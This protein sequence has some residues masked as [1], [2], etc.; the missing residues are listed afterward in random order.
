MKKI[1]IT[2]LKEFLEATGCGLYFIREPFTVAGHTAQ[3]N[4]IED[5]T[6]MKWVEEYNGRHTLD[7]VHDDT[8]HNGP[9]GP[10]DGGLE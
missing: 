2:V 5:T 3:I 9:I 10:Q 7:N 8:T 4:L 1:D 6:L